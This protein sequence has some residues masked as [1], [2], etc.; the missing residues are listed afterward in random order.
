LEA[1]VEKAIAF[2]NPKNLKGGD[3]DFAGKKM[4]T[5]PRLPKGEYDLSPRGKV[6]QQ[7][8]DQGRGEMR[9]PI[10]GYATGLGKPY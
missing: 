4:V 1:L 3:K 7:E 8:W 5:K 2:Q 6:S 9:R 10:G